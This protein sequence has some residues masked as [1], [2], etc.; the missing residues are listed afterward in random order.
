MYRLLIL[1]LLASFALPAAAAA[2]RQNRRNRRQQRQ[3]QGDNAPPAPDMFDLDTIVPKLSSDNPDEVREAIDLLSIID[4]PEVIPHLAHVLRSGQPDAITDRAVEALGGLANPAAI[5]V[6]S[7]FRHHRRPG[8]RR[9]AY[10][11]LAAISDR[12]IPAL[13]E[14][15]LADSDRNVRATAALALG[16]IGAN[17]SLDVLFR[18][19]ERGV[20]EAAIAIGKLGNRRAVARF[21]EHLGDRPLAIMLSGYN[22][23]LRRRDIPNEVKTEVVARLGEVSGPMVRRF[24]QEYLGSFPTGRRRRTPLQEHVEETLRRIPEG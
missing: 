1:L 14:R 20:V 21:D 3:G 17:G 16:E 5:D 9:R 4:R 19:F 2:Q 23:F 22:E 6:L 11:G 7:A 12:R 15:G 10:Q 13:L 18:A 8:V 24:L